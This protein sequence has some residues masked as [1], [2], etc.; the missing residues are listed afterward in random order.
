M[1]DVLQQRLKAIGLLPED[2]YDTPEGTEVHNSPRH[3][4]K[5]LEV[6][7]GSVENSASIMHDLE[8]QGLQESKAYSLAEESVRTGVTQLEQ[9]IHGNMWTIPGE[10]YAAGEFKDPFEEAATTGVMGAE[11]DR[12]EFHNS[13]RRPGWF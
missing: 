2:F 13:S 10:L 5:I 6:I 9:Y 8:S 1:D 3:L 4:P 7:C 11:R 12:H